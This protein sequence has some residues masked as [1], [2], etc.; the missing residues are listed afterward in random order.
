MRF[1]YE[2]LDWRELANQLARD[3]AM[4]E[5]F[6]RLMLQFDGDIEEVLRQLERQAAS[7]RRQVG[8][9]PQEFEKHLREKRLIS[10]P[11]GQR[12]VAAKGAQFLRASALDRVFGTLR[13]PSPGEHA[14]PRSGTNGEWN[15]EI[16]PFAPGDGI[17]D[18]AITETWLGLLR[19]DGDRLEPEDLQVRAKDATAGAAT[20]LLI[21]ISHSMTLYGEDRITP[22]KEV[23]LAYAELMRRR[24]PRD[25]LDILLFGDD[26]RQVTVADLPAVTNGP[27]HTNT[28]EALRVAAEILGKRHQPTKRVAMITDGKPTALL[29]GMGAN[30]TLWINSSYGLDPEIT[31]ATLKQAARYPKLG[32]DLTVFMV[33]SDP[34]L[35]RFVRQLVEV[36]HGQAF[37]A[38][39]DN[40]G[41]Q[42]LATL[43]KT[44]RSRD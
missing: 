28:C 22:A 19:R 29:R 4:E 35:E 10:G 1:A 37:S 18:L 32:I 33:A 15:G 11:K 31:T 21:D 26:V 42:V 44:R 12:K 36:S 17:E 3:K 39:L 13:G 41:A 6:R 5:L 7:M 14:L 16:R 8:F 9:D 25:T 24:Y 30:R 23:A 27:F 34:Y 43:G 40:L 38:T 20:V 2:H